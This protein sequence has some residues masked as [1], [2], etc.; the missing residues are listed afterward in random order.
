MN[1]PIPQNN[2]LTDRI[3]LCAIADCENK[4]RLCDVVFV[5]GLGGGS[6]STWMAEGKDDRFWPKWIAKD[7]PGLGV[8]TLGYAA[9]LS[10]WTGESMPIADRGTQVLEEFANEGIGARPIVFVVHSMGGIVVKQLLRHAV[11]YGVERYKPIAKQTRGIV[12]VATPHSGSDLASFAEFARVVLRT[13]EQV[14]E[15]RSHDSRLRELHNWFRNFQRESNLACRTFCEKREVRTVAGVKLPKGLIVVNETSAEPNIPGE[16]AIP[17]DEDHVSICKPLDR[18]R[19]LYKSVRTFVGSIVSQSNP[20]A[21]DGARTSE[22]PPISSQNLGEPVFCERFDDNDHVWVVGPDGDW[23]VNIANGRCL[24]E[25]LTTEGQVTWRFIDFSFRDFQ[26]EMTMHFEVGRT[27]GIAQYAGLIFRHR[28]GDFYFFVINNGC[29]YGIGK[30]QQNAA[31][32]WHYFAEQISPSVLPG[33]KSNRLQVTARGNQLSFYANDRLLTTIADDSF[34][35]P[36]NIGFIA[37]SPT[38]VSFD[39]LRVWSHP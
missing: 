34:L 1:S 38:K 15:L 12:F 7:I 6:H 31:E 10:G 35:G 22:L 37:I 19:P 9:N 36:G 3:G 18:E 8:W 29:G 30:R 13:N 32:R 4:A 28:D 26:A 21:N 25:N 39:E 11:S 17:L 33:K 24:C 16:V 5:H 20:R 23:Q 2:S 14:S 27:E